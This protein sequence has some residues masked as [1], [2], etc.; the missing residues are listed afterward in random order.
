MKMEETFETQPD[1]YKIVGKIDFPD[2][3]PFLNHFKYL[4]T[5]PKKAI[6]KFTIPSPLLLLLPPCLNKEVY[7]NDEDLYADLTKTYTKALKAFYALGLRYLQID[8]TIWTALC[9]ENARKWFSNNGGDFSKL[10]H[11]WVDIFNGFLD[12][13]PDD[14]TVSMHLCRGNFKSTYCYE[15]AYDFVAP[16]LFGEIKLDAL[17]LEYDDERSGSFD[18]LKYIKNKKIDLGNFTS[19]RP[20][21]ENKDAIKARVQEATKYVPL[22][23]LCISTQCGFASTE[24]GNILTEE[25]E[26][27]KL[28]Y[29]IEISKEIWK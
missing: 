4:K 7:P 6:C 18:A 27:N 21:L 11:Q 16:Y 12:G 2:D 14:L 22:E 19:K 3:H 17:F 15:G 26:F 20:E 1:S 10:F 23:R 8:D 9:D 24:E 29:I 28:K 13:K 25:E 5:L